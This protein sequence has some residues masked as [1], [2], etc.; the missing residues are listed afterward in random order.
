MGDMSHHIDHKT[1]ASCRRTA[2]RRRS[3]R[4]CISG[5]WSEPA[6]PRWALTGGVCYCCKTAL[7]VGADGAIYAAWRHV[8]PGN[9]RDIAFTLSRDGGQDVRRANPGERRQVGDSMAVRRMAPPSRSMRGHTVR[10]R[11]ADAHR[12]I[13]FRGHARDCSMRHRA[14]GR[15]FSPRADRADKRDAASRANR[16][17]AINGTVL[18]WDESGAERPQVHRAGARIDRRGTVESCL[19]GR[20]CLARRRVLSSVRPDAGRALW[21]RPVAPCRPS[22][23]IRFTAVRLERRR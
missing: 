9:M 18:V 10:S 15:Q 19:F 7:A 20:R 5:R 11:V 6:D 14:D 12:R 4:S 17:G 21:S 13:G 16:R 22:R 2:S 23:V 3:S 8:Y 1:S